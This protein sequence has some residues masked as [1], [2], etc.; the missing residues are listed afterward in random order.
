MPAKWKVTKREDGRWFH[1]LTAHNGNKMM[2]QAEGDGFP[3][4]SK[5]L[6]ALRQCQKAAATAVI[7]EEKS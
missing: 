2:I 1:V 7:V 3:N 5:A 4:K 6:R